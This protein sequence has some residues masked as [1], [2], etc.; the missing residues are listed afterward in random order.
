VIQNPAVV[1]VVGSINVDLIV[2]SE[3]LPGPGETV[4]GGE[5]VEAGGGK[6]AN[7]AVAA[8]RLGADVRFI[9]RV[10]RDGHGDLALSNFK[11]EGL[12]ITWISVDRSCATGVAL[13]LVDQRG[14]NMISVASGANLTLTPDDVR[15]AE[16][17]F[18]DAR[19]LLVQLEVPV[20]TVRTALEIGRAHGLT[21]ILNPAPARPVPEALLRLVDWATPNAGE[22]A[23]MTGLKVTDSPSAARAA[24]ALRARGPSRVVVTLGAKGAVVVTSEGVSNVAPFSIRAVD[25][26]AAGDAFSA[27]LAVGLARGLDSGAA[28]RYASAAGALTTTRPGAQPSLPTDSQVMALLA[29]SKTEPL[30]DLSRG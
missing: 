19:V 6:G 8:H 16:A 23:A 4:V 17:A 9:G 2:R 26:T 27:G 21:T 30:A 5:F 3:R 29:A 7:Q 22:A 15:A 28:L 14:E 24:D 10:G 13:I 1:V 25:S 20:E 18:D 12:P 11:A